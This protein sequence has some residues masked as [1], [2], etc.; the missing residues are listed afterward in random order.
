MNDDCTF[1]KSFRID[2]QNIIDIQFLP[3]HQKPTFIVLHPVKFLRYFSCSYSTS[4][5]QRAND[6]S[7]SNQD[8]EE[9]HIRTYQVELKENDIIKLSWQQDMTLNEASFLIP[10]KSH[11]LLLNISL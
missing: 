1:T 2:E 11:C 3:G 5:F 7:A 4:H 10:S 9:Y 8:H 6:T